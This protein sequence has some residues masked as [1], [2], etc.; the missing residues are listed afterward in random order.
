MD[1][2]MRR[3]TAQL[4]TDLGLYAVSEGF[5]KDRRLVVYYAKPA[6]A[7]ELTSS[8]LRQLFAENTASGEVPARVSAHDIRGV[9]Q[10][11][12]LPE[13]FGRA[14]ISLAETSPDNCVPLD[15][16]V[17]LVDAREKELR[18]V[19][20]AFDRNHDGQ[21]RVD[22]VE[23][24][25]QALDIAPT[26]SDYIFVD[27]LAEQAR[28]KGDSGMNFVDFRNLCTFLDLKDLS[29]LGSEQMAAS[30][31]GF[32]SKAPPAD[33]SYYYALSSATAGGASNAFSRTCVAPFERLRLQMAV[34]GTKYKGMYDCLRTI[35]LEEGVRGLWRGNV[36]NVIRIAPQGAIAFCT[37]DLMKTMVPEQLRYTSAG[38]ALASMAS[39]IICMSSVYPLDFVRGRM[40]TCPGAYKS[41]QSALGQ[42]YR[43]G[44]IR[45]LFEG[46]QY[47]NAW[48]AVYYGV[49]FF[50]YD[51]I[52]NGYVKYRKAKGQD[53]TTN[54]STG[55]M[56]GAV[57]GTFCV[58]TAYP[59]ESVRRKLQVQGVGGRPMLYN[60]WFDCVKKTVAQQG[61]RGLYKGL[62]ANMI[63]TPPSIAI[64]FGT[65][66][67]L[68]SSVFK[69]QKK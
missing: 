16:L 18:K 2:T 45:S 56:F 43:Q 58:S 64:T 13:V 30:S 5:G 35:W 3:F 36:L 23:K 52:K 49:Q 46:V 65:Y 54:A 51:T 11:I 40:T 55:V 66:E 44:G 47:S 62:G 31:L 60:G 17:Q 53:A 42:I 15:A 57:S 7:R 69:A 14:A 12:G 29:A 38:L 59:F 63:K 8:Y 50:S 9:L 22:D 10:K 39:G 28:R 19:F 21:V 48:A 68:M 24:A 27:A 4:A 37:K 34:D 41:W 33:P 20:N 32:Q 67:W 25:L 1:P 26:S 61:V 6:A